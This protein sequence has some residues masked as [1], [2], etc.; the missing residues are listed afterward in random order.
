[1]EN[2]MIV[3]SHCHAGE[4][5]YEPIETLLSQMDSNDVNKGVLI[6]HFGAY[7]NNEY[8]ISCKQRF[9]DR[10]AVVIIPDLRNQN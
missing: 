7:E 2:N 8:L 3:D 5:W 4:S 6:G 9:P 10:F 1:M